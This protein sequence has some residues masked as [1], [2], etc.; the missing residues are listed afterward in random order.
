MTRSIGRSRKQLLLCTGRMA[1]ILWA[2]VAVPSR[3]QAVSAASFEVAS[4]RQVPPGRGYTSISRSESARFIARNVSMAL[5]IEMA[6]G[7]DENQIAGDKLGWLNSELYDVEAKP[8]GDVSLS[9]EQLRPLLQKLLAQRFKLAVH[10]ERK[11]VR[12]YALTI[13]K[14]G[15]RLQVSK[16]VSSTGYILRDSIRSSSISMPTLAATLA[17]PVGR[18]V[19]DKTG[20]TGNYDIK[21]SFA[22]FEA[23]N[24]SLP[25]I[26]TALQEQ[27]GLRLESEK[28][29]IEIL[30]IDHL[31]KVPSEN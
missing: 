3:A 16:E 18:P 5:L 17:R 21:L 13:A 27:L 22:P 19:I 29:P 15:P 10:H 25:S 8:E 7:V 30:V 23:T 2:T 28:V 26:F 11:E 31:E 6:F 20:I 14:S 1:I 4:V 12:G 24:S 9:Y